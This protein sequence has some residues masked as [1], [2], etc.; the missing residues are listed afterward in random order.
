MR[1]DRKSF[2]TSFS[3]PKKITKLRA[4]LHKLQKLVKQAR[5]FYLK[6]K[7][8][9]LYIQWFS[10]RKIDLNLFI[11]SPAKVNFQPTF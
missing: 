3:E 8:K 4:K 6:N 2:V 5:N 10:L 9:N 7:K 1:P 11:P